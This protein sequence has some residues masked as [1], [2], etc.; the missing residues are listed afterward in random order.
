MAPD[1]S[2]PGPTP[3]GTGDRTADPTLS[4]GRR[5]GFRALVPVA[6]LAALHPARHLLRTWPGHDPVQLGP[7]TAAAVPWLAY[8][9]VN[10]SR[11]IT[12][13][14]RLPAWYAAIAWGAAS[15]AAIVAR[16]RRVA[17]A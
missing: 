8:A 10:A 17:S 6:A 5:V 15:A 3:A 2:P 14:W 9:V 16:T 4:C 13:G 7:T 1:I 11:Q 12:R